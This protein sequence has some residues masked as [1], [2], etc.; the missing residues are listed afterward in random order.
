MLP[1]ADLSSDTD[2]EE[3]KGG[4]SG[5]GGDAQA[6]DAGSNSAQGQADADTEH[7]SG[8]DE[9]EPPGLE[10]NVGHALGCA[11]WPMWRL[12]ALGGVVTVQVSP[13]SRGCAEEAYVEQQGS[14][15]REWTGPTSAG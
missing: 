13:A 2:E 1:V 4:G 6:A 5:G 14:T 8:S 15:G 11:L 9:D 10:Y 7:Q 12:T 3:V